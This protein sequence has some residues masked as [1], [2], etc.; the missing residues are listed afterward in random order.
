MKLTKKLALVLA[1]GCIS[2]NTI[3]SSP[4]SEDADFSFSPNKNNTTVMVRAWNLS[5]SAPATIK[6]LTE[7]GK[8]VYEE[9]VGKKDKHIKRYDFS[10]MKS[11]KYTL[12][13]ASKTGE[14]K[15]P[16][17]VGNGL[18]REDKSAAYTYFRPRVIEKNKEHS[19]H[20]AFSNVT[21]VPLN[22]VIT[23]Y[24]NSEVYSTKVAGYQD[25]NN[26]INLKKLPAGHYT[27]RVYNTEYF[28]ETKIRNY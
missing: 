12:V 2:I 13:L 26:M 7:S 27:V 22:L 4:D 28:Y 8:T 25:F 10:K 21:D 24:Q 1:V 19:L 23:N 14:V 17:I 11:G 15:K 9:A 5:S 18:V 16:F 20:I 3:A 6:V